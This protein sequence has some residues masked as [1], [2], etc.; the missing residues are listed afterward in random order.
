MKEAEFNRQSMDKAEAMRAE[1]EKKYN[2]IR[3]LSLYIGEIKASA[4]NQAN[5]EAES[6]VG[7][8]RAEAEEIKKSAESEKDRYEADIEEAKQRKLATQAEMKAIVQKYDG[9]IHQMRDE[10]D[11]LGVR[12]HD[13]IV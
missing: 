8:A 3:D 12:I 5:A 4:A 13:L 7:K 1:Y 10:L 6:I 11:T 9:I 2:D